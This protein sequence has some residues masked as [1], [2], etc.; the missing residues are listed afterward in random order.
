MRGRIGILN[1]FKH[2]LPLN[3]LS[4]MYNSP[5][6]L[7]ILLAILF[8]LLSQFKWIFMVIPKHF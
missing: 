7:I 8:M 6:V 3:M 1:K 2:V 5:I 4:I